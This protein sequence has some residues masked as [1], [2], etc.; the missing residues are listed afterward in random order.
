MDLGT[1]ERPERRGR[2]LAAPPPAWNDLREFAEALG[3]V[4][5]VFGGLFDAAVLG[6][7]SDLAVAALEIVQLKT[8]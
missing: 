7:R 1:G 8:G 6:G 4:E 3:Y 5:V 2:I